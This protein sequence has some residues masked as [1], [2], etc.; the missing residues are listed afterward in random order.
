MKLKFPQRAEKHGSFSISGGFVIEK[1]NLFFA[2]SKLCLLFI[3]SQKNF[4][5]IQKIF[6]KPL[7]KSKRWVYNKGTKGKKLTKNVSNFQ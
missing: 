6:Q 2:L 1:L 5:K 7:D 3:N 4:K